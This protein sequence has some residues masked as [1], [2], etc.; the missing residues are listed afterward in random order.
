MQEYCSYKKFFAELLVS[1][2]RF[3]ETVTVKR[4]SSDTDEGACTSLLKGLNFW[5]IIFTKKT[6]NVA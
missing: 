1:N 4:N 3:I 5:H 6:I 2:F